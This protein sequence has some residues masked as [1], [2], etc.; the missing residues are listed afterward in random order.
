MLALEKDTA[1]FHVWRRNVNGNNLVF[2]RE[3]ETEFLKDAN[4][5]SLWDM[6][7]VCIE[8]VLKGQKLEPVQ[9]Y[10]EFWHSWNTFHPN[11]MTFNKKN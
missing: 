1:S 9:A 7:G 4:T 2:V 10:Q 8:G 5:K 6:N 11:T 3:P